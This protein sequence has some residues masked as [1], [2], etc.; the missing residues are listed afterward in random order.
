MWRVVVVLNMHTKFREHQSPSSFL[1]SIL[2]IKRYC[3]LKASLHLRD[4]TRNDSQQQ[5]LVLHSIATLLR[6]CFEWLQHCSNIATLC[7]AKNCLC[8]S[9]LVT[10]LLSPFYLLVCETFAVPLH[11]SVIIYRQCLCDYR[12]LEPFG[13]S[14]LVGLSVSENFPCTMEQGYYTMKDIK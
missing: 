11:S 7:S 4:V 14:F 3:N 8:G 13:L 1:P 5:F 6:H 9:S 2:L 12:L 10:L